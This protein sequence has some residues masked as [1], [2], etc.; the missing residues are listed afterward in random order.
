MKQGRIVRAAGK[1]LKAK[2]I[3][4]KKPLIVGWAITDQCNRKCTYCS[5]WKRPNRDLSTSQVFGIIDALAES[6][7]MR[8]SFTGG[9]PLLRKDMADIICYVHEKGIETKLNSNGS[10]VKEKIG[11]LGN[12]DMLTLSLEGPQE[13]HDAIRGRGSFAEV[14]EAMR[15]AK[16]HGIKTSLATVLTST[17]LDAVD[18]ILDTAG[19]QECR[20]MFQPATPLR[21]GGESLN[22]LVSPVKPYRETINRLIDKKK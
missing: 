20:V 18:Y 22:D 7:T 11:A 3:K 4:R 12:L 14:R 21:L 19:K 15:V 16:D 9:E 2:M 10:L 13:I 6:G 1:F 17:N 8:I 5:I